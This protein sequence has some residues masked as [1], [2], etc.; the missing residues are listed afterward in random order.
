MRRVVLADLHIRND[1]RW[2]QGTGLSATAQRI[3]RDDKEPEFKS[4]P[5]KAAVASYGTP[6]GE[7]KDALIE[8]DVAPPQSAWPKLSWEKVQGE[9][10]L[11]IYRP[12]LVNQR[13]LDVCG[14]AALVNGLAS[15][16]PLSY[17]KQ[18][19]ACFAIGVFAGRRANVTLCEKEPLSDMAQVDWMTLT[20]MQDSAQPGYQGDPN[21]PTGSNPA[22]QKIWLKSVLGC[23]ATQ[24]YKGD[25]V[26]SANKVSGLL[27]ANPKT[28][29]VLMGVVPDF[30]PGKKKQDTTERHVIRLTSAISL[31]EKPAFR[32]FTW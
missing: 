23:L 20:A 32:A 29:T 3:S 19:R 9:A 12:E 6:K 21:V 24:F 2:K 8:L 17:A 30:L 28:V 10:A 16:Q 13:S 27:A 15:T 1:S 5:V 18:V 25:I 4:D 11:R 14:P 31:G 7:Q 22:Q 26:A